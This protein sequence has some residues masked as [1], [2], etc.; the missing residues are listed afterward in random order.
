M[1]A[2]L[3][4]T[5]DF[6]PAHDLL[7]LGRDYDGGYLVSSADV[8]RTEMLISLGIND[9]WS[10]EEE[11]SEIKKVPII[12]YDGSI[13]A[14]Y[15]FKRLMKYSLRFNRPKE[16]RKRYRTL[17]NYKKFFD[18]EKNVHYQKFVGLNSSDP[19]YITLSDILKQ[20]S[21]D[22]IFMKIDIE[23]SEYR[24]LD[25]LLEQSD[26]LTG[27]AI[28]FHDCDLNLAKIEE[29]IRSFDLKL[30]HVHANNFS[31]IRLDDKLPLTLELSFSKYA[32][33]FTKLILPH[34]FDMPNNP[35]RSEITLSIS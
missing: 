11:F 4:I 23:G 21:S 2:N 14:K 5:L 15:F 1:L 32:D 30:V 34:P 31:P 8:I 25:T 7:R 17:I 16:I 3:P 29:F 9:D 10:F 24:L 22:K 26:R 6:Q 20:V 33:S 12:A 13:S 35:F 28:E 27:V 18:D 19:S